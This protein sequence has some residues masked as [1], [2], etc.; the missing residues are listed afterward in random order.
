VLELRHPR[1]ERGDDLYP[2]CPE[3]VRALLAVE[4]VP[5][6]CWDPAAGTGTIVNVL[7]GSG[8]VVVAS[9]LIDY[10]V[11][12]QHV[13]WNF[14]TEA[15]CPAGVEAIVTNP[16]YKDAAPFVRRAL[17]L[18]PKVYM[19]LRLAFLESQDRN[20]ILDNAG[21]ARVH[22]F[23][24]RLP[25]MHRAGWTGSKASSSIAF[26]WFYWDRDHKGVATIDRISWEARREAALPL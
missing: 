4:D 22:V 1:S 6:K 12:D 17:W 15:E 19:L 14:L 8:R 24:K 23:R 26:A 25:M 10:K 18:V 2:T 20:D 7:R 21:L 11:P 9:D 3:A 5:I 16:P 13:G